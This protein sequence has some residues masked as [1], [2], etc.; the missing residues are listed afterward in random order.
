[1]PEPRPVAYTSVTGED[2]VMAD[3]ATLA[4]PEA[5]TDTPTAEP[6][7]WAV[8]TAAG[9]VAWHHGKPTTE[10]LHDAVRG[11]LELAPSTPDMT[12]YANEDGERLG[13]PPNVHGTQFLGRSQLVI[14]GD[15]V[16]LGPP[17]S[18]GDDTAMTAEVRMRLASEVAER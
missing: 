13:L 10:E 4:P 17:D 18:D 11:Y 16:I 8:I 3:H 15:I 6:P 7:Y 1:M 12:A 14:L 5:P 9:K 2:Y